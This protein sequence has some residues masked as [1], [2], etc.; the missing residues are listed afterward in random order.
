MEAGGVEPQGE[1]LQI[2]PWHRPTA[3]INHAAPMRNIRTVSHCGQANQLTRSMT[4]FHAEFD[5]ARPNSLLN[6][7]D[8]GKFPLDLGGFK[9]E[10]KDRRR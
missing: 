3:P 4:I 9:I 6:N 2:V 10:L 7:G 8:N 1:T 5:Q